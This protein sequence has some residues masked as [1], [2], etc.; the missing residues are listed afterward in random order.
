VAAPATPQASLEVLPR[1][2]KL[3]WGATARTTQYRVYYKANA[4]RPLQ[5]V[6]GP[7]SAT[8]R[9]VSVPLSAH[10]HDWEQARYFVDACNA[11]GCT[12]SR[13][14]NTV[15]QSSRAI[16]L[17]IP[18]Y[19]LH[20]PTSGPANQLYGVQVALSGDGTTLAIADTWFI[21]G[22]EWPWYS[23]GAVYIY[24]R[25]GSGWTLQAKL[26]PASAQGY[27]FF[28]ADMALSHDGNTLA[29][30]GQYDSADGESSETGAGT[31]TI[32]A[33]A[34][35]QWTRRSILQ[36]S[37]PQ[38]GASF[39]RSVELNASGTVLAVGAPFESIVE[40]GR[41]HLEAGA[42]YV[43][44]LQANQWSATARVQAPDPEQYDRFGLGLR[45]SKNGRTL[46]V[47]A[48]EQ[49]EATEDLDAG[50]FPNR[51]N[52]VYLF[53]ESAN[54]WSAQAQFEGSPQELM[55]GGIGYAYEGQIEAFD[56]SADG[57]TLAIASPYAN[58]A[59]GGIGLVRFFRKQNRAWIAAESVTPSITDRDAF[60]TR[61][62]L[63][64]DGKT[65]VVSASRD[66]GLYGDPFVIAF[67]RATGTWK[68]T[69]VLNSPTYPDYS[70]FGNSLALTASG[71]RLAVGSRTFNTDDSWW[72]AALIY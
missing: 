66:D 26:Q 72:G 43:Y 54:E 51:N 64:A 65:F 19:E 30:G 58:A 67:S 6:A 68:Q 24:V 34:N 44:R 12:R 48:G 57:R 21:G 27:D 31:V 36:A 29:V 61:L 41:T 32:F 35:K 2:A 4:T 3:R 47:L 60:G 59:D 23:S 8:T 5:Q 49:N 15:G 53:G 55:L 42:V 25:K 62:T 50:G 69:A 16:S 11:T 1:E 45:L 13:A 17:L 71:S 22:A 56:L 40:S 7:L 37:I 46:A 9:Q 20:E 28:G 63:S 70:T 18:A 14:L 10:L 38:P 39:G 33:R 52:T